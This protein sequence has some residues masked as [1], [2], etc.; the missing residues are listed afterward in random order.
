MKVGS[1]LCKW[2][3]KLGDGKQWKLT[4][5]YQQGQASGEN[6]QVE[7]QAVKTK[8]QK[9]KEKKKRENVI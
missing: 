8:K 7:G 4:G 6:G 2:I 9:K 3:E 5:K 1:K